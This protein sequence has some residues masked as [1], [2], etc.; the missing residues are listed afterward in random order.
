[1]VMT[2]ARRGIRLTGDPIP[3]VVAANAGALA[4]F[5]LS[6]AALNIGTKT[7]VLKRL[8]AWNNGAGN[9][10]IHIGTGAAGAVVDVMPPLFIVNNLNLDLG[11]ADLPEVE[12]STDIMVWCVAVPVTILVEIEELS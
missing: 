10:V 2:Y 1:M 5:Q 3:I 11:E 4:V 9:T 12:F 7:V 8:K 6:L